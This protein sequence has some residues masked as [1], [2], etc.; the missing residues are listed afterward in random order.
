MEEC[1]SNSLDDPHGE[2][3]PKRRSEEIGNAR[4]EKQDGAD[5][6]KFLFGD[7]KKRL[8][9]KRTEDQRRNG[10]DPNQNP[11]LHFRGSF[12]GKIDREGGKEALKNEGKGKQ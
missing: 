1:E 11:D 4:K 2:K 12:S 6:H 10:E 8:S 5:E 9:D 3:R 7:F